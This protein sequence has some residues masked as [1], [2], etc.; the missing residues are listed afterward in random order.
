MPL[1]NK[2]P[3][4]TKQMLNKWTKKLKLENWDITVNEKCTDQ[5]FLELDIYGQVQYNEPNQSATIILRDFDKDCTEKE[6]TI[7]HELLHLKFSL[8][9]DINEKN[10][11]DLKIRITEI[12]I[13][14]LS[15][16]LYNLEYKGG[17]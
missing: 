6:K 1:N 12:I 9:A 14:D 10:K 13:E 5:Q 2:R 7:I 3:L 16:L 8:L 4:S 11:N 17:E 15:K